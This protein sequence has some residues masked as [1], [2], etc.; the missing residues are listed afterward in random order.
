MQGFYI[1]FE[2]DIIKLTFHTGQIT[3]RY[4]IKII[5]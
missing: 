5:N 4:A 1:V 3:N 2:I